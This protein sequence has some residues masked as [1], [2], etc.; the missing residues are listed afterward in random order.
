MAQKPVAD[1]ACPH[2]APSIRPGMSAITNSRVV[3]ADDP[4]IGVQGRE[5]IIGDLGAGIRHRRQEGRLAGIRQAQQTGIGD[6]LQPQPQGALDPGLA[7][8]GSARRLVGRGLEVQVAPAAIAAFAPA[9]RAGRS[10]PC[11]RSPFPRPRPGSR[12]RPG[13]AARCRRRCARYAA[14]PC[15]A[16]RSWRRNAAGSGNRSAC[17]AHPPPRP[18]HRRRDRRRRHP[19]RRIRCT[20]RGGSSSAPAPPEPDRT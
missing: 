8:I 15:R 11:R 18:R 10:R 5:G 16:G 19:G 1:P 13:R 20:S 17:S 3:D 12:C 14:C 2:D 9:R 7:G 6:Q 4:Q